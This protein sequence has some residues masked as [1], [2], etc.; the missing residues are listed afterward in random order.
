MAPESVLEVENLTVE[1]PATDGGWRPVLSG[2]S[3][4]VG[5]GAR[6]GLVGESGSGKSVLALAALG[7]VAAPGRVA[8][9]RVLVRG[10]DLAQAP[11]VE[12]RRLRGGAVGL[13]FQEPASAFNPVFTIGFQIAE[14]V[15]AHRAVN[16][17]DAPAIARGLLET[18]AVERPGEVAGSY[19]HQLSGG[20]L[21]RAMIALALA[22][23]PELLIA[24]EPT[25][26]LDLETQAR[27]LELLRRLTDEGRS[28]LLIS[29]DLAVVAGLVERVAVLFAGEIVEVAPTGALFARPLHPYTRW[30]LAAADRD[31]PGAAA[32]GTAGEAPGTAG[33]RFASRC[34]I[35][36][37]D[38][39]R[40][41]P[42]LEIT[43]GGRSLRCPVVGDGEKA[44]AAARSAGDG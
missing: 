40:R 15:R 18:A 1:Y 14:A 7:L 35:A 2:V 9:G 21:Q 31:Q 20:Q 4:A 41:P 37:P 39:R 43:A 10:V 38:C 19:P 24:D 3:L 34:T 28:L 25:S 30:L 22:G 5:R 29:H 27:I 32:A 23:G 26:A 42:P 44:D 17:S 33:C 36:Q 6:L 8:G 11:P 12:L 13:V 16:R